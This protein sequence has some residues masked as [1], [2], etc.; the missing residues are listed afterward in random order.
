MVSNGGTCSSRSAGASGHSM[1]DPATMVPF[2]RRP[3]HSISQ[4]HPLVEMR[5]ASLY[6]VHET[7]DSGLLAGYREAH[8]LRSSRASQSHPLVE[9]RE[10]SLYF[11]HETRDSGLL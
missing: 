6:F 5:E 1:L 4:S 7:R 9:M 3:P 10:A 2:P 11:V 8:L